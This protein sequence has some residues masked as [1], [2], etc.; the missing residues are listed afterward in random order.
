MRWLLLLVCLFVF[1]CE[2]PHSSPIKEREFE[3]YQ[4]RVPNG[5]VWYTHKKDIYFG[6]FYVNFI[7]VNGDNIWV[8][9]DCVVQSTRPE[10]QGQIDYQ[11]GKPIK[12]LVIEKKE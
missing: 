12:P 3:Y 2:A 4:V 1:G 6:Q 11:S 9:G 7:A 5:Q 10:D 8:A